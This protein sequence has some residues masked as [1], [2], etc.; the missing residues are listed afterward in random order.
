MQRVGEVR[1]LSARSGDTS[2]AESYRSETPD[3]HVCAPPRP[4]RA[5][6]GGLG[7]GV[8]GGGGS[9]DL[10]A[11]CSQQLWLFTA[12]H[13]DH[14]GFSL[15]FSLQGIGHAWRSPDDRAIYRSRSGVRAHE[16]GQ[17]A[18][19][20]SVFDL[21]S[22]ARAWRMRAQRWL[23]CGCRRRTQERRGEGAAQG[24]GRASTRRRAGRG[25]GRR[26]GSPVR[27]ELDG[28]GGDDG[29]AD[30]CGMVRFCRVVPWQRAR[31]RAGLRA[32]RRPA[33]RGR[34]R[35]RRRR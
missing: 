33:C 15:T 4:I 19:S 6:G 31:A 25:R 5:T 17:R 28:L 18:R 34:R 35:R 7:A 30:G 1:H 21:M 32:S 22:A 3:G 10:P 23:E 20:R 8:S 12:R 27:R 13:L 16:R 14:T 2:Q 11:G 26:A 29:R 9:P 24:C